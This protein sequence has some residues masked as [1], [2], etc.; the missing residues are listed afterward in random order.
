[1]YKPTLSPAYIV[2]LLLQRL[3]KGILFCLRV[4]I[5]SIS[6]HFVEYS[7]PISDQFL[8]IILQCGIPWLLQDI[9]CVERFHRFFSRAVF[10]RLKLPTMTYADHLQHLGFHSLEHL[11]VYFDPLMCCKM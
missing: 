9:R 8:N 6:L 1:M 3:S 11:R 4:F 10:K 5:H 7:Y 2:C